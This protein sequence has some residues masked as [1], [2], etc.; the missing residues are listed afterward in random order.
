M[1]HKTPHD[2]RVGKRNDHFC[3]TRLSVPHG[4]N[5]KGV[6][7]TVELRGDAID[8]GDQESGLMDME[9]VVLRIF[10]EDCPLFRVAQ[11]DS[12]IGA[13]FI[14]YL[15]IDEE[16]RL[17]WAYRESKSAPMCDRTRPHDID[18]ERLIHVLPPDRGLGRR[19]IGRRSLRHHNS[20]IDFGKGWLALVKL[21]QNGLEGVPTGLTAYDNH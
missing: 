17:V 1:K 3:S 5:T 16:A 2:F 10:V 20:Q 15:V 19:N 6:A 7:Q 14:E 4:R 18:V 21:E 11:L 8:F 13:V 12:H 9:V